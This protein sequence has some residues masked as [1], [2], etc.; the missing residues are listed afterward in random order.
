[1]LASHH[2]TSEDKAE[3][4]VRVMLPQTASPEGTQTRRF[5]DDIPP[6]E[7]PVAAE[8]PEARA[9]AASRNHKEAEKRRR[10]RINSHLDRL[11]TLLSCNSK[12]D[13]ASL[14]AKAIQ[15]VKELQGQAS[16]ITRLEIAPSDTDEITVVSG[17][18]TCSG[19][20][21]TTLYKASLCC[22]DRSGLVSDI[23]ETLRSLHLKALKVEM[24]TVGGRM[25]NVMVVAGDGGDGGGQA[26][27]SVNV[28]QNAFKPLLEEPSAAGNHRLK[29]QRL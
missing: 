11:R 17:D 18:D 22:E 3:A 24:A 9:L 25:R 29:R 5:L 27:M 8:T 2:H 6:W 28:L 14:L 13:K 16:E 4:H 1:M 21:S 15:R 7:P 12:T 20:L 26:D 10:Q 23:N 19:L